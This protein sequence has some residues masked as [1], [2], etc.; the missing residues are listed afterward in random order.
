MVTMDH[1]VL[2][3]SREE[4]GEFMIGARGSWIPLL[5]VGVWRPIRSLWLSLRPNTRDQIGRGDKVLSW[6]DNLSGHGTFNL[7]SQV[8]F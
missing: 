7:C 8:C 1:P 6:K 2:D 4:K 5:V 3:P